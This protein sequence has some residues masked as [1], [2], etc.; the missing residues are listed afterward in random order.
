MF[1][2]FTNKSQEGTSIQFYYERLSGSGNMYLY[3]TPD[4][5]FAAD[6]TVQFLFQRPFMDFDSASDLPDFPQEWIRALKYGLADEIA[7]EYGYPQKDRMEL[8][9][10]AEKYKADALAFSEEDLSLLFQP[11]MDYWR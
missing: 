9:S 8:R 1:N 5:T 3:L 4:D 11:N 6:Y 2:K 10:R 7:F